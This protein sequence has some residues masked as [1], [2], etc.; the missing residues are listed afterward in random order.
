MTDPIKVVCFGVG[1][2]GSSVARTIIQSKDWIEIVG[3]IDVDPAKLGKDLGQVVGTQTTCGV[4]ISSDVEKVLTETRP[5]IV[6]H[7]TSSSFQK[8][9]PELKKIAECKSNIISSCE[10]LSY[11]YVVDKR[12]S[13][14]LDAVAKKHDVSILGTGINPG[15]LMDVLP[16]V[17]TA[18]CLEIRSIHVARQMNAANRRI[19][20]QKKIGVGATSEEFRRSI[21]DGTISG[22]VG[23]K[24][25]ISMLADA[26]GWPI[27]KVII[28]EPEP[29]VLD[30]RVSS[31]WKTVEPGM[32]AGIKQ[33]ATGLVGGRPLIKYDFHA[34][35]GAEEEYDQVE[36]DGVPV[37]S[38][39]S[40]PCVNGD[41]GTVAILINIIPRVIEAPP[42]LVTMR[43]LALPSARNVRVP[44]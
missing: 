27:D 34:Y 35:I 30:H 15:F 40:N 32:V 16:I 12:L 17:L 24:Q 33:A 41:S 37:V 10:E 39:R 38:F 43:D 4:S 8:T 2:I 11:P 13:Q 5:D 42:G 22:H 1:V 18:P 6:I 23:L 31:E 9:F 7:T 28:G 25:S 44:I 20:F 3:A 21:R 14:E 29:V 19:P 36:I 26:I